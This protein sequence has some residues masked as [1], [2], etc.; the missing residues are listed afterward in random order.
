MQNMTILRIVQYVNRHTLWLDGIKKQ[1]SL[2]KFATS[3]LART[4]TKKKIQ[5]IISQ[6]KTDTL[7][8]RLRRLEQAGLKHPDIYI[9]GAECMG[10]VIAMEP[11]GRYVKAC[12]PAGKINWIIRE[13]FAD[14]FKH[15]PFID[16]LIPVRSLS[17]GYD[18]LMQ[19]SDKPNSITINCHMDGT[20]C[21]VTKR[22]IRNP[23]NP[24]INFFSYY[25]IGTLLN[26]FSLAAGLPM[27]DEDPV[28]YLSPNEQ[29]PLHLNDPYIVIQ[30]HSNDKNRDWSNEKWNELATRLMKEGYLVVEIGMPRTIQM[31]N[32]LYQ[33]F[34]GKK[35]LQQVAHLIH[36][37]ALFIGI[38]SGF[39]HFAHAL[40]TPSVV[41]LGKYAHYDR[42][43]PYAGTFTNGNLFHII[44]AKQG[45]YA[46]TITTQNVF[47]QC[48]S[49][50]H[51]K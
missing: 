17:E 41:L 33:D 46:A 2:D 47:E 12:V 45:H 25:S 3:I 28:F 11:I 29:P 13:C 38:D 4:P 1:L 43:T 21:A 50:L 26:A 37:A 27:L 5:G 44:R 51:L 49:T 9:L 14:I 23:I 15:A 16:Q 8:R 34:T 39:A 36:S 30:C 40:K 7:T 31:N 19:E 6:A 42:Y 20:G 48:Q 18:L 22:I 32:P 10:D 35:N 24:Q